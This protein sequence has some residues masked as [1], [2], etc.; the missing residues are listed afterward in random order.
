MIWQANDELPLVIVVPDG[1]SAG[2]EPLHTLPEPSFVY[3]AVLDHI[4]RVYAEAFIILAPANDFGS[5]T[6]EQEAAAAYLRARGINRVVSPDSPT[7]G[8]ID[9]RGNARELRHYLQIRGEWPL[10]PALL[11]AAKRHARRARMCYL[12]EGFTLID[13]IP[14]PY[15]IPPGERLVRR[16]WYYRHPSL[17]EAYEF[18]AYIRDFLRPSATAN[19][20]EEV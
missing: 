4:V 5:Y 10:K 7:G 15:R 14:V 11:V 6:T 1:L 17:H 13:T 9:T 16:L 2:G 18:L 12:K 8:Y 20:A 19:V 3:R